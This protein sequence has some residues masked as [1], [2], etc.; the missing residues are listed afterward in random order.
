MCETLLEKM[1]FKGDKVLEVINMYFAGLVEIC[2][3]ILELSLIHI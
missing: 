1:F 3:I 2:V